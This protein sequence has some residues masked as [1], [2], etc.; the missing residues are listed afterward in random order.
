MTREE[1]DINILKG[2]LSAFKYS[3]FIKQVNGIPENDIDPLI[4]NALT[5]AID[6]M[7]GKAITKDAALSSHT[8]LVPMHGFTVNE[9][10]NTC[11]HTSEICEQA[12][13]RAVNSLD[14]F[15][16]TSD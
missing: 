3:I 8:I 11:S 6:A 13:K 10:K 15:V 2:M 14:A 9:N 4:I 1:I 16:T 12:L 7:D 5:T